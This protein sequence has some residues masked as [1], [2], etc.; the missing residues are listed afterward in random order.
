MV[1]G[2]DIYVGGAFTTAGGSSA[3]RIAKWDGSSWSALGSG[4]DN[5]ARTLVISGTDLYVGGSFFTAGDKFSPYLAKVKIIFDN[6][7]RIFIIS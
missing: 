1:I 6:L 5:V 3:N 2:T 4:V 7:R